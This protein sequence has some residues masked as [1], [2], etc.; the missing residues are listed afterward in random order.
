MKKIIIIAI[1]VA[2]LAGGAV[3]LSQKNNGQPASQKGIQTQEK[4]K[5]QEE[6]KTGAKGIDDVCNYFP[7]ELVEQAIGR[8]IVKAE[9]SF[10]S[11]Y[12]SCYY[13][14]DWQEDFGGDKPGGPSIIVLAMKD[15]VED[16]KAELEQ[17]GNILETDSSIQ[18][19]HY[20]VR[21]PVDNVWR[22]EIWRVD[23]VLGPEKVIE[24]KDAH[25][26]ATGEELVKIAA[27]FAEKINQ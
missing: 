20:T 11:S 26:A 5:P 2:V 27:K 24:I 23:I 7:K 19:E 3:L 12:T 10:F 6:T 22:S 8:P 18:G 13:Y 15:N 25:G 9:G 21:S 1:C 17:R 4:V 16:I 14:T